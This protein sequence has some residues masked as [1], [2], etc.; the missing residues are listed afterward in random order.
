MFKNYLKIITRNLI[1]QKLYSTINIVGFA[2]G[3]ACCIM[4]VLYIFD[5][6]S[7]DQFHAKKDQIYRVAVEFLDDGESD[8]YAKTQAPL[9]QALTDEFP[10]VQQVVRV[11]DNFPGGVNL[12]TTVGDKQFWESK[13]LL[14]DPNF[15]DIFSFPMISGNPQNALS[16][17]NSVVISKTIAKKYFEDENPINKMI[18]FRQ[19]GGYNQDFKVTGVIEDVQSNSQLQFDLLFSF[20]LQKGNLSWG[21]WNYTTYVLLSENSNFQELESKFSVIKEKYLKQSELRYFLQPL[22]SVH[23]HSKLRNDFK[24]NGSVIQIYLFGSIALVIL[25]IA[26]INYMNLMT[27]R[28]ST[29]EREVG[30]RKVV[31]AKRIQLIRQFLSE[32]VIFSLIAFIFAILLVEL[33]LPTFNELASK[34]LEFNFLENTGLLFSLIFL[35]ITIGVLSGVYPAF[36]ISSLIPSTVLKGIFKSGS[37]RGISSLNKSLIVF[38]FTISIILITCTFVIKNQLHHIKNKNLGFEKEHVVVV[39]L[40]DLKFQEK[41]QLFKNEFIK[42]PTILGVSATSYLPS[43]KGYYQNSW[44]EGMS[45]NNS[46]MINW[47]SVDHDFLKTLNIELVEGRDF[48]N[49]ITSDTKNAYILNESAVKEIG[50][51]SSLG[52][53]FDIIEKGTVIGVIKDFNFKS[54]HSQINPMALNIFPEVYKYLYVRISPNNIQESLQFLDKKWQGLTA[55]LPF[56]YFFLDDDFDRIYKSETKLSKTFSYVAGLAIFIACLGLLGLISYTAEQKTK[57][58]GIRKVLGA[59]VS[60]I[61]VYLSKEFIF[62]ILIANIIGWPVVYFSMNKWLQN[63]AYRM[64]LSILPFLG[65]AVLVI[66][67]T[68]ISV[69]FQTTKAAI[70]NPVKALRYE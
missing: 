60:N 24:T 3:I 55:G 12:V 32:S 47:I 35:T 37:K 70:A 68:V 58:I 1:K 39:P 40:Y 20:A 44:W 51:N 69:I 4:L 21:S 19:L 26:C 45:E 50:W 46:E 52:K 14:A 10:E 62:L 16:D 29:R 28:S 67:I 49:E 65:A 6:L 18:N 64:D 66:F 5:E 7:F 59:S 43:E 2:I 38:Q 57:E 27:V 56:N 31:G 42:N 25:L 30:V 15:F 23:L 34:R 48:S 13:I 54:L 61:I 53:Q 11:S 36:V 22:T 63:F 17:P 8:L 9:A 41:Y 33:F